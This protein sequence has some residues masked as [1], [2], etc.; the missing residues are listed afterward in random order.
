M[1]IFVT[2][3]QNFQRT[4]RLLQNEGGKKTKSRANK[5]S[6]LTP[7]EKATGPQM[8]ETTC[9]QLRWNSRANRGAGTNGIPGKGSHHTHG[10]YLQ[11]TLS[12]FSRLLFCAQILIQTHTCPHAPPLPGARWLPSYSEKPTPLLTTCCLVH[13]C[14]WNAPPQTPACWFPHILLA[15]VIVS[16]RFSLPLFNMELLFLCSSPFPFSLFSIAL[17]TIAYVFYFFWAR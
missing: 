7:A 5:A 13:P 12:D 15:C 16:V 9:L 10:H 14:V 4:K 8:Q 2:Q 6:H 11:P 3:W 17:L 1:L